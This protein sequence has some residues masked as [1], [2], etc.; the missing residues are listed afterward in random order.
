MPD[1][2]TIKLKIRRGTDT[3]RKSVTLEQ[4]ELGYTI[5]TRRVF[6]GDGVSLGGN[7]VGNNTLPPS[8]SLVGQTTALIGD[9]IYSNNVL[10]QL[11]GTNYATLSHWANINAK[12]DD[13][14]ITYDAS[15]RLTVTS[16]LLVAASA[17]QV[18]PTGAIVNNVGYGI[19]INAD[20][21]GV[22]VDTSSNVLR[23]KDGGI[24]QFKINSSALDTNQGL[25]G[26]SG[27]TIAAKIDYP[28][29]FTGGPLGDPG[30][31]RITIGEGSLSSNYFADGVI[32][33]LIDGI[34]SYIPPIE[35]LSIGQF[36]DDSGSWGF[37]NKVINGNFDI[38]QRYNS[39]SYTSLSIN[40]ALW[41]SYA[42]GDVEG[43]LFK[44]MAAD[45]WSTYIRLPSTNYTGT[46]TI[47]RKV[48]DASTLDLTDSFSSDYYLRLTSNITGTTNLETTLTDGSGVLA[49]CNIEDAARIL[50][51]TVTL[52]FWARSQNNTYILS[53]SQIQSTPLGLWTPTI[54]N[55]VFSLSSGWQRFTHTY[56]MPTYSQ[57]IAASFNPATTTYAPPTYPSKAAP[58]LSSWVYQID[59]KTFWTKGDK[60]LHGNPGD[61]YT[62]SRP[63]YPTYPGAPLTD[64]DF[65]L[66]VT[67]FNANKTGWYDIAQIQLEEGDVASPFE[68]KP[69]GTELALC[70]RYYEKGYDVD[71]PPGTTFLATD[72]QNHVYTTY[73][74]AGL[75]INGLSAMYISH[76]VPFKVTKA[77][78]PSIISYSPQ[79]GT[80]GR[81]DLIRAGTYLSSYNVTV[82]DI[83][84]SQFHTNT[85]ATTGFFE[86]SMQWT[87]EAEV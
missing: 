28:L 67:G 35:G 15:N 17:T 32:Q 31:G 50:G 66:L 30:T 85:T 74:P 20:N 24:T 1:I 54:S 73:I 2:S 60:I 45:R 18:D 9:T 75:G 21:L 80:Q 64:A 56:T 79:T 57:V 43:R 55:K 42:T 33:S 16:S 39:T 68:F 11:T 14:Y 44:P 7:S 86:G 49:M 19:A 47:E 61:V 59:L 83:N 5:D 84:T 87:A 78:T 81:A 48:S 71:T 8:P 3:Q 82:A 72:I 25:I 26:G 76:R 12:P 52:S 38:W 65:N 37:K 46:Y 34:S 63:G 10:Y 13:T 29:V 4:G 69:I 77:V 36:V 62:S 23:V 27:T 51:K 58:P 40:T 22:Y 41:P 70:Q 6:I 53:E